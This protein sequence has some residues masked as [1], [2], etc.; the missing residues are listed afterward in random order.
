MG[1]RPGI[2]AGQVK[3][4]FIGSIT[5]GMAFFHED[6]IGALMGNGVMEGRGSERGKSPI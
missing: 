4:L 1:G 5:V 6:D 3:G 2:G